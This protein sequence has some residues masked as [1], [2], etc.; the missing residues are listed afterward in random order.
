MR[1]FIV[2]ALGII[3]LLLGITLFQLDTSGYFERWHQLTNPT[4]S[5]L[6]L[7]SQKTT[8]DE[9]GNPILC[10]ESSPEFSLL[11]NTPKRIVDCIQRIDRAA[12]ATTRT[13]YITRENGEVWTW[14]YFDYAYAYYAKRIYFPATGFVFGVV[15][16]LFIIKKRL[17]INL[18]V[19]ESREN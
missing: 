9:Y 19:K 14:S 11:S 12:D 7:F 16:A 18:P 3:G 1:F 17:P 6:D 13:V 10:D 8:P 15:A 4:D 2:F 5:V